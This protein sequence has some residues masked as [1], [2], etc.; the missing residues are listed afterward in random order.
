MDRV[1]MSG[2][3]EINLWTVYTWSGLE[4]INPRANRIRKQFREALDEM[5]AHGLLQSWDCKAIDKA[6]GTEELKAAKLNVVFGEEQLRSLPQQGT[7]DAI[8]GQ[9]QAALLQ[10]S[11]A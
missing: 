5:V 9:G 10:S 1:G 8:D 3:F 4:S 2:E 11:I 6:A 7:S